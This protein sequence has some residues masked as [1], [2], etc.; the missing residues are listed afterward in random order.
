MLVLLARTRR[1]AEYRAAVLVAG[2][3]CAS[4][5]NRMKNAVMLTHELMVLM[6]CLL[7]IHVL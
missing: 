3:R 4:A 6:L 1:A 2:A 7:W 5:L